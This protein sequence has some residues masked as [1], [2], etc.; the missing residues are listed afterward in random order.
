VCGKPVTVGV[1]HRIEVL[2]DR[3]E[4][5]KPSYVHP[6]R[7]IIPLPEI[8][9]EVHRVGVNSKRVRQHYETLLTKLGPELFIL[10]EAS[11]EDIS[12]VGGPLLAEGVRRMRHG[13][14]QVDAGFDGEYG[15]VKLFDDQERDLFAGQLSFAKPPAK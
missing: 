8:L 9:S 3:D 12:Q 5:E 15:V 1:L 11:L 6:Y 10:Q 7:S 14:I 2:A 4:G 13:E